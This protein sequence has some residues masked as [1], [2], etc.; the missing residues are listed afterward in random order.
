MRRIGRILSTAL[1]TAGLVVLLDVGITLAWG[2]P[3][4]TVRG[5]LAQRDAAEELERLEAR[6]PPGEEDV[7]RGEVSRLAQRLARRVG[8]GRAIGRVRIPAIGL[9]VVM[10]E[11][12][13]TETLRRGP[14]HYPETV[15]PGQRG[16]VAIAGHRTT[17][18]APFRSIDE[19]GR[20]DEVIVDMP[21]ARFV[22]RFEK[23]RIVDPTRVG[24]V[25]DVGHDRVVLTACH[26]LYSAAQ[27]IVVFARLA[28]VQPPGG[29]AEASGDGAV[30]GVA[31]PSL[32]P[33]FAG[34]AGL[35]GIVVV[36]LLIGGRDR[37]PPPLS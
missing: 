37:S 19:I 20:G 26:P 14:G 18:L 5:W 11:G 13:E 6:F 22:Y 2:E 4:S 21:Y 35:V 23:Q 10:V 9:D 16:T 1:I 29:G 32:R 8:E 17:Y 25:R 7:D 12:T 27:R 33:A 24:V 30:A 28:N 34:G 3:V 31:G 15:L 36:M